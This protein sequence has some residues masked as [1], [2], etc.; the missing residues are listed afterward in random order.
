MLQNQFT[1][2][3]E[4]SL[5]MA[6]AIAQIKASGRSVQQTEN[7]EAIVEELHSS[8]K[9]RIND[10]A[11]PYVNELSGLNASYIVVRDDRGRLEG[12]SAVRKLEIG[13]ERLVGHW[14]RQFRRIY[15][16]GTEAFEDADAPP[17]AY[18]IKGRV[19]FI[20]DIFIEKTA[21]GA[22]RLDATS[23]LILAFGVMAVK[24]N[25]DWIYGFTKNRDVKRGLA[26]RYLATG[27]FP[28]A[29]KW[30]VETPNRRDDDWLLCLSRTDYRYV[31]RRFLDEDH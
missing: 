4:I 6:K 28:S 13:E 18:E 23:I 8:S 7:F 24:W 16:K 3:I 14:R 22:G 21:R 27:L 29:V 9:G 20:S 12:F 15:G 1:T 30:K 10:E 25:P 11:S 5:A 19:G 26:A 17:P 2:E 31:L